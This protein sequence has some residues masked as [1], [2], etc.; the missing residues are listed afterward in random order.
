MNG[1]R[2]AA[3]SLRIIRQILRDKRTLA[4]ILFVPILIMTILYLV[5]TNT[6]SVHT[7]AL[8]R[9]TGSG[10]E[11]TNTLLD[12]FLPAKD[13]LHVISIQADQVES[14]L[15][16]GDADAALIFPDDFGQQ[17]ANGKQPTVQI[18]LEGSDPTVA[19]GLRDITE[20]L[21]HQLN[22]ALA[23][24]TFTSTSAHAGPGQQPP[25]NGPVQPIS[26]SS[27]SVFHIQEPQYLYGG[28]EYT[29]NDSLAPAFIGLFS[30]F[31]VFL[32]TS[33]AFLR[34]RT[35]GTLER[36]L[37]SPLK[38]TELVL[39]YVA[40]FLLFALIQSLLILLFVV[41]ALRIHYSGNLALVFLVSLLLT[42]G[43]VN[44]GIFLSTF[45]RNEFQIIQFVPLVF[46]IQVLLSGIL[47]PVGQLPQVLRLISYLLPLTYANDALRSV[48]LK[49]YSFSEIGNQLGALC[50]FAL[51]MI[52]LSAVVTRQEKI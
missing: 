39:G 42:I 13:K 41:F 37:V 28:A 6:N 45:A 33:V 10:S 19:S 2:I 26:P 52:F 31:F 23:I 47:W 24:S 38:R 4:L 25:A 20:A 50:L 1:R 9:P 46:G 32:L 48:M 15:K 35:Q 36:V 16:K 12:S 43:S 30:F 49:G 8:V 29:F 7:L 5:L 21:A 14:T 22:I 11:Q 51:L 34:E 18:T 3:L 27:I 44:L 40:G 17:I